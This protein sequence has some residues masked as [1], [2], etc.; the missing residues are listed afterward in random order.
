M[1]AEPLSYTEHPTARPRVTPMVTVQSSARRAPGQTVAALTG[2]AVVG[3][4]LAVGLAG[5]S[6]RVADQESAPAPQKAPIF[7]RADHPAMTPFSEAPAAG[8]EARS[9]SPLPVV[10]DA[11]APTPAEYEL[12]Q[13][14]QREADEQAAKS[15]AY[16]SAHPQAYH[17][18][19]SFSGNR[20]ISTGQMGSGGDAPPADPVEKPSWTPPPSPTWNRPLNWIKTN[21]L[22][23]GYSGSRIK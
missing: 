10:G 7:A 3:L 15:A 8:S 5:Y 13:S 1:D 20:T 16:A 17:S 22:G 11:L 6:M 2:S 4:S 21:D 12:A 14:R 23:G 9:S 19:T 18:L